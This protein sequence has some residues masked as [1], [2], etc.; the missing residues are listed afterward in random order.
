MMT[1]NHWFFYAKFVSLAA[2]DSRLEGVS[3][4]SFDS[5]DRGGAG[6][7]TLDAATLRFFATAFSTT[8]GL[9]SLYLNR[10]SNTLNFLTYSKYNRNI[11]LYSNRTSTF[12][13][14][15]N[16]LCVTMKYNIR[17]SRIRGVMTNER[18]NHNFICQDRRWNWNV[19]LPILAKAVW[20]LKRTAPPA[21]SA[22]RAAC[23]GKTASFPAWLSQLP[24]CAVCSIGPRPPRA[25]PFKIAYSRGKTQHR[26]NFLCCENDCFEA[27]TRCLE[28]GERRKKRQDG[29]KKTSANSLGGPHDFSEELY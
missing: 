23:C 5:S 12:H 8:A 6:F 26:T 15:N 2:K 20:G 18:E 25:H 17:P 14:Y 11:R 22:G 1:V 28:K 16:L 19:C 10:L 13:Q 24:P 21:S 4:D 7:R 29:R 3:L 9:A 27:H